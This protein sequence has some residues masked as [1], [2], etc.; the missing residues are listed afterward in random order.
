MYYIINDNNQSDFMY[1]YTPI[2]SIQ[3]WYSLNQLIIIQKKNSVKNH[4]GVKLERHTKTIE[5]SLFVNPWV[6]WV[7]SYFYYLIL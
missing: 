5:Q 2:D 7:I 6:V 4:L 1:F 3:E